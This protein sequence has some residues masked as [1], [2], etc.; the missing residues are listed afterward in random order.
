MTTQEHPVENLHAVNQ[1]RVGIPPRMNTDHIKRKYLNIA[2]ANLSPTQKMDIYLPEKGEGPF[3]VICVFHGGAWMFGAKDDDQH[4]P[5]LRGLDKGYAVACVDYRLSGEAIFPKQIFD[6]KAAIRF[7]KKNADQYKL[8]GNRIAAWGASAGAH[9][10]SLL[11]TTA[12]VKELEDLSMG[13]ADISCAVQAVID[14]CGPSDD[15][16]Q[17]DVQFKTSGL[18][19]ADHS[20]PDSPES[21]LIGKHILTA[22]D[23]VAYASPKTYANKDIPPFLIVHGEHDQVVPVEQSKNFAAA[24]IKAAGKEKVQL[25]IIPGLLHHGFP[26]WHSL[27]LS[28][29]AFDFLAKRL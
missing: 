20:L 27:E 18:G 10:A 4:E 9:L 23:L 25:E 2:Y 13:N 3:P 8:D 17:M 5:M 7:I 6:C 16:I 24:L 15:F 14:W 1:N 28:D 19:A 21:R 26:A 12:S 22:P 11:G 29:M